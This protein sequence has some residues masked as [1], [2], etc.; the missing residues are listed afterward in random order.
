MFHTKM[1]THL[2]FLGIVDI[3][4]QFC[5]KS[6]CI[7][8][9]IHRFRSSLISL[10]RAEA[11]YLKTEFILLTVNTTYG[12]IHKIHSQTGGVRSNA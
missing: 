6:R 11:S 3:E 5:P 2:C 1:Q 4:I 10:F 12:A 9:F 8:I 7:I